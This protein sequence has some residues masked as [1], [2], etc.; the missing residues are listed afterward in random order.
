MSGANMIR[1]VAMVVLASAGLLS[2]GGCSDRITAEGVRWNMS[3]ELQG[4]ANTPDQR[5]N[6]QARSMDTTMRQFNDDMDMVLM[7]N[8]PS[9]LTIY[10]VP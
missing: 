3:P 7:I 2:L 9:H 8:K 4:M 1:C 10:P 5:K 6:T